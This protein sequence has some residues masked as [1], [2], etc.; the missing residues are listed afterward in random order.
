[1]ILFW[2]FAFHCTS[3][4]SQFEQDL[5][6]EPIANQI[7]A[8]AR[9]H[10]LAN[11][12]VEDTNINPKQEDMSSEHLAAEDFPALD[13]RKWAI[14]KLEEAKYSRFETS[15]INLNFNAV[16]KYRIH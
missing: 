12:S 1:M 16:S 2:Q 7:V 14:P 4:Q 5:E 10:L 9:A 8:S 3:D 6:S 13:L 11:E 15:R